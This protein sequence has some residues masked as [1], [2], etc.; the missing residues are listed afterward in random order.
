MDP[1]VQLQHDAL[2]GRKVDGGGSPEKE[3][4]RDSRLFVVGQ[5]LGENGRIVLRAI[6]PHYHSEELSLL[7]EMREEEGASSIAKWRN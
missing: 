3:R 5:G 2:Q 7:W 4:A 6:D 1:L